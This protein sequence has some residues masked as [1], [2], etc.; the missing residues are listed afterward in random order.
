MKV[1]F[2]GSPSSSAH[3]LRSL[4]DSGI[5]VSA[6]IT[7]PDKPFGRNQILSPSA[8]SLEASNIGLK[9]YKPLFLDQNF[10]TEIKKLER[11]DFLIVSA[12][13][14]ILPN[15][16]LQLPKISPINIHFSLLPKYR[17]ASPI[18]TC[19]LNGDQNFGY[20][21]MK[22][23][24]GLDTGPVYF[25]KNIKCDNDATKNQIE[26]LIADEASK[27]LPKI[28][29]DIKEGIIS[30]AEQ[31]HSKHSLCNKITKASGEINHSISSETIKN[32]FRAYFGWPGIFFNYK[33]TLIKIHGL[34]IADSKEIPNSDNKKIG[35]N[36]KKL[37][38]K[39]STGW[40]V[41]TYLQLPGKKVVSSRD[42]LNSNQKL[43]EEL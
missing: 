12:Y 23:D 2:A 22:M 6:V 35:T 29:E 8:V 1:F 7:Q 38:Y 27:E 31:D 42:M 10:I 28:L 37:Y 18:Q 41:I 14:K 26:N 32:M 43:F 19:L 17:G 21:I 11:P 4:L 39:T 36:D 3:F 16:L 24:Q 34:E 5:E 20:S 25:S 30:A 33:E 15:D 13:G 40:I 9:I